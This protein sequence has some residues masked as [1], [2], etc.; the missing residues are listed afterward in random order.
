ML[1]ATANRHAQSATGPEIAVR[2]R[3]KRLANKVI[4]RSVVVQQLESQH[5]RTWRCSEEAAINWQ[6]CA[7]LCVR[8][9]R[10]A[11]CLSWPRNLGAALPRQK[12]PLPPHRCLLPALH[13]PLCRRR[14]SLVPRAATL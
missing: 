9:H 3:N 6:L 5:A 7:A 12:P 2:Y 14:R 8:R 13:L 1:T 4:D 10:P 11:L